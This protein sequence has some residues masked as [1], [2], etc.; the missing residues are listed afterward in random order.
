MEKV[1]CL[2]I[3]A[4][5]VGL[6]IARALALGGR[7]VFVVEAEDRLGLGISSRNSEVIHAGIYYPEKSL[8]AGS[9]VFGNGALYR[10]CQER[11]VPHK[12]LGKLIVA[13]NS[14]Q[15][16]MLHHYL[17]QG[18]NNGVKGLTMLNQQQLQ[19]LEPSLNAVAA[20]KSTSTGIIDSESFM[21]QLEA[22]IQHHRGQIVFKS[23]VVAGCVGDAKP[24]IELGGISE[25]AIECNW[26]INAAGLASPTIAKALGQSSDTVPQQYYAKGHYFSYAK[27]SL[28][29]HLIYPVA[30]DGGLGIHLTLDMAGQ[31]RFGPDVQW[32]EKADY[33]FDESRREVF[34]EHI[35]HYYPDVDAQALQMGYTGIRPKL[36][37]AGSGFTDFLIQDH[38]QHGCR[39]LV[40]LFGIESPGL[41]SS[42]AIG[43]YVNSMINQ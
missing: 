20:L 37:G 38:S 28:F 41:T 29:E 12:Q 17:E 10:Y 36:G 27:P 2:V 42:L 35:R 22:D 25:M 14:Q 6:A 31:A 13:T 30:V 5:V 9:C 39:G 11:A 18:R 24:Q 4:G 8:K 1:D 26:V 15:E 7:E 43:E 19:I 32:L 16:Q 21:R 23:P 3:G 40:N 34:I 33:S